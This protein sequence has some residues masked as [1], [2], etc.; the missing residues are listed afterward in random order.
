M[1]PANMTVQSL[2]LRGS[3]TLFGRGQALCYTKALSHQVK[4]NLLMSAS[5]SIDC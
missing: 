2:P 3:G 1:I 4:R 5:H